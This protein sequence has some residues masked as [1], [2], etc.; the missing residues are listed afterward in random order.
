M[1]SNASQALLFVE[2]HLVLKSWSSNGCS[3]C[4]PNK[5]PFF[6]LRPTYFWKILAL[7][8]Q[9]LRFICPSLSQIFLSN[10]SLYGMEANR[11]VTYPLKQDVPHSSDLVLLLKGAAIFYSAVAVHRWLSHSHYK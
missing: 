10:R 8:R 2:F 7:N 9:I 6:H 1:F 5:V 11:F 3:I 4:E